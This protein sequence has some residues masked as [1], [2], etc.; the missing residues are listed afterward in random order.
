MA[1][2]LLTTMRKQDAVYWGLVKDE[3]DRPLPDR[4]GRLQWLQPV[5]I[6]VFWIDLQELFLDAAGQQKMSRSK[7]FVGDDVDKGGRLRQGLL[8]DVPAG[9]TMLPENLP[10]AFS[11]EAFRKVPTFTPDEFARIVFL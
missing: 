11:I 1:F 10:G 3:F 2:S 6:K 9:L 7:V 8:A 4:G 5:E